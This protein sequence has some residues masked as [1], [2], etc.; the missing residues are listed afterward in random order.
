[1]S[2]E[3]REAA[4]Y[5]TAEHQMSIAGSCEIIGISWAAWYKPPKG[6]S[7][8]DEPLIDTLNAAIK[9]HGSWGFWKCFRPYGAK[10]LPGTT[11]GYIE[12]IACSG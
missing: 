6:T 7:G 10:A 1:M 3:K 8:R 9:D 11:S 4:E 5:L 12:C 2:L